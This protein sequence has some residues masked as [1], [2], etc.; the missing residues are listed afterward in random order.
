MKKLVFISLF[1]VSFVQ[2]VN[3]QVLKD[4]VK[5]ISTDEAAQQ[6]LKQQKPVLVYFYRNNDPDCRLMEKTTFSNPEVANYI[7]VLFYPVRIDAETSE[8]ITFFNGNKFK[9]SIPSSQYNDITTAL[10]GIPDTFPALVIFSREAKGQVFKGYKT[11]DEIF[12]PLIYFSE[13]IDKAVDY[14]DWLTI[15]RK[16]FP[17]GKSQII[18]RLLVRWKNL[19]EATEAQKSE[20]R[21]MILNMYNYN[22]IAC[23]LMR[24]EVFNDS[25]V[26]AYLNRK[27]YPVNIDVYTQDTL[28]IFGQKYINENRPHKFHQLP[29]AALEGIMSFPSFIILD[30]NGKVLEKIRQF[31]TPETLDMI[32]HYY[33]ENSYKTITWDVFKANYKNTKTN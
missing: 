18:T 20:P 24:T 15:H 32:L 16:G 12:R 30:E 33:G 6:F 5:W 10:V 13:D 9:K 26:A 23:S 7:N 2:T 28:E 11:R 22:R 25:A 14:T 19:D 4:S 21:K 31:M 8:E 1:I 27:Y 3:S 29:I 17:P